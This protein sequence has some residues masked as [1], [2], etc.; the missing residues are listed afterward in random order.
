MDEHLLE[1][2]INMTIEQH[3]SRVV[4]FFE[5][6][7][8]IYLNQIKIGVIK[9]GVEAGAYHI[10]QL[11]ILPEFQGKGL[12]SKVL[13]ICKKKA[14]EKQLSL[15]LNVLKNNPAKNLYL[16]NGFQIESSDTFMDPPSSFSIF[17]IS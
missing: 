2:G 11:Q 8:L 12:G 3:H 6:S 1:A 10:R 9:L 14:R 16:R 4:E 5:D 15:T 13:E 7:Y 17:A